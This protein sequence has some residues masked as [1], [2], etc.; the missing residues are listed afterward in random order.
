MKEKT[1]EAL[2]EAGFNPSALNLPWCVEVLEKLAEMDQIRLEEL[3]QI[4]EEA[5][6]NLKPNVLA[7]FRHL[8]FPNKLNNI[9]G[10]TIIEV[11]A[12][13]PVLAFRIA[14]PFKDIIIEGKKGET[15]EE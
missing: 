11:A 15:Q 2:R 7:S 6:P 4:M 10:V 1:M 5:N 3:W 8:V 9:C 12:W 14:Q 13:L